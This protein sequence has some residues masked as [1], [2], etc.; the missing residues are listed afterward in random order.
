M[1]TYPVLLSEEGLTQAFE[2][3]NIYISNRKLASIIESV[4]GVHNVRVRRLFSGDPEIHI[5][6][7]FRGQEFI[8]EEPFGDNSRYWIGPDDPDREFINA[9]PIERAIAKHQPNILLKIFADIITLN[10]S[11]I[12]R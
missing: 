10:L 1:K 6:F 5:R 3:N 8:V 4:P 12:F 9:E 7:G 11:G 2:I